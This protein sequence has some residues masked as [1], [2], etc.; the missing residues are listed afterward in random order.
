LTKT[1]FKIER[2]RMNESDNNQMREKSWRRKLTPAEE[3][4][5]RAWLAVHPG[6][7]EDWETEARLT[8]VL[9]RLPEVPV[10]SNFTACVLQAVVRE[11]V[12]TKGSVRIS[13]WSWLRRSLLPRAAA[14]AVVLA[15]GLLTY[16]EHAAAK[17]AELVQ[18]VKTV[19]GV[20][21]LPSPEILQDF[22]TIRNMSATPGPDSEL[23]ALMK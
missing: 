4:E 3:A 22:D 7:Q 2:N 11:T 9:N 16:H 14:A 17:R 8:E 20:A 12:A 15:V 10:P 5:L 13:R 23:I 18:S 21:S 1:G 19:S 6:S